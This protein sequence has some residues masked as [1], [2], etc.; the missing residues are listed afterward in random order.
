MEWSR[1]LTIRGIKFS[2]FEF[3]IIE[4]LKTKYENG[5][6]RGRDLL[7]ANQENVGEGVFILKGLPFY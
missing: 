7:G 4:N 1:W 5:A 3:E 2:H 6:I